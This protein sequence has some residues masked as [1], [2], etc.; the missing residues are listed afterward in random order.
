[1][2]VSSDIGASKTLSGFMEH[3]VGLPVLDRKK[4]KDVYIVVLVPWDFEVNALP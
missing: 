1:M 3:T 2:A 4:E